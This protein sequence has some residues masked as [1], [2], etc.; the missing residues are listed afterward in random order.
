MGNIDT[1]HLFGIDEII[2]FS[3]YYLLK[4]KKFKSAADL[5][6]NIGLHSIVLSKLGYNVKSYEP[7]TQHYKKMLSQ[8]KY[9]K[10]SQYFQFH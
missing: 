5:G 6:A 8:K 4:K 3:F 7:D 1:T 9:R 2:I 10:L